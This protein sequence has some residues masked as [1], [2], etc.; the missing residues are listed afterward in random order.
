M[1]TIDTV[2]RNFQY[3]YL[4]RIIP[5]N[6][7]LYKCKLTN[8]ELCDFCNMH[9]ETQEH[10]FWECQHAQNF[11]TKLN[12]FLREREVNI[13]W[14]LENI[15]FGIKPKTVIDSSINY[16]ILL[17]KIYIFKMKYQNCIPNIENFKYYLQ[18]K[19]NIEKEIAFLKNKLDVHQTKWSL[20]NL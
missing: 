9:V 2:I 15:S 4:K 10:L 12:S 13:T 1:S 17:G 7:Y 8:S 14:N 20:F 11:W 5:T 18:T 3:K 19:I 16:I 6:K